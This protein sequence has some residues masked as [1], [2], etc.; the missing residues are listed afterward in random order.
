MEATGSYISTECMFSMDNKYSGTVCDLTI[1][2]RHARK[3]MSSSEMQSHWGLVHSRCKYEHAA[4]ITKQANTVVSRKRAHGWYTL[5]CAQTRGWV[6]ICNIAAFYHKKC[7]C[8]HYHNLQDLAHQ[9]T[10][11]V[12]LADVKFWIASGDSLFKFTGTIHRSRSNEQKCA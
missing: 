2:W 12:L 5:L 7:P 6:D 10:H 3:L 4:F 8:L 9:H 1:S 11:P